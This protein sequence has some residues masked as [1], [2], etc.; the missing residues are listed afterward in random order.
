MKTLIEAVKEH[1]IEHYT[2][3]GWDVIVECYSDSEIADLVQGAATAGDAIQAVLTHIKPIYDY[4][5]DIRATA[6]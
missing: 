1:A 3:D 4:Q 6:W 5:E 2:Q